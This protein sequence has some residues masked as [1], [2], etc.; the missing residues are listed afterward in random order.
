MQIDMSRAPVPPYMPREYDVAGHRRHIAR[1]VGYDV[2]SDAV[3]SAMVADDRLTLETAADYVCCYLDAVYFVRNHVQIYDTVAS[4]W[5]PFDLWPEQANVLHLFVTHKKVAVLKS[6]QVGV[7]WLALAFI[8]W[9]A[10]FRPPS[11]ALILSKRDPDAVYLLGPERLRGMFNKLPEYMRPAIAKDDAHVLSFAHAEGLSSIRAMS[12]TS[13]DSYTATTV[14]V[15]EADLL[16]DLS[17][18]LLSVEPTVN[19]GGRLLLVSKSDRSRP[20]SPF[21][22]I[23]KA[24]RDGGTDYVSAFLAWYVHP[25]RDQ[26]WYEKQ[27]ATALETEG[28][29]DSV[30]ESYPATD[31]EALSLR[32]SDRRIPATWLTQVYA[33]AVLLEDKVRIDRPDVRIYSRPVAGNTYVIGADCAEGLPHSDYS[34]AVV[35][36]GK[37]GATVA[38]LQGRIP[39]DMHAFV[40][41]QLARWYND[42][43]VL[44]ERNNHGHGFKVAAEI[45]GLTLLTG[46]DG[47]D[48]W[49]TTLPSKT[50][51]YDEL[52]KTI[53]EKDTTIYDLA[54]FN[55]V[56]SIEA[57][58]LRCPEGEGPDRPYDDLAVAYALASY[59]RKYVYTAGGP[60]DPLPSFNVRDWGAYD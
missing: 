60:E 19:A 6:R 22:G 4:G 54:L 5:I 53:R 30:Y 36:Q 57:S 13:G 33:D 1:H 10:L 24:G 27:C 45:H 56:G 48:G 41:A 2:F 21:K 25:V 44:Y 20:N 17:R 42:A 14:L 18:V 58:T 9:E 37:T 8:L 29:L 23:Y 43:P 16:P 35:L 46:E 40:T 26:E 28:T 50:L 34:T 49:P 15:D 32:K 31:A 55:E 59:A 7:T 12:T 47:R 11:S 39:P 51:L 3:D 38:V 52:A